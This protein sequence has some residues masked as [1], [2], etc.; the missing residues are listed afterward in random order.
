MHN[1]YEETYKSTIVSRSD[2]YTEVNEIELRSQGRLTN[3][4][5]FTHIIAKD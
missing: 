5:L 4:E 1:E 3:L 2:F